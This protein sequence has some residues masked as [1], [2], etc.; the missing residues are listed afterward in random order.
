MIGA[1]DAMANGVAGGKPVVGNWAPTGARGARLRVMMTVDAVGG[2]WRYAMVLGRALAPLGIRCVFVGLGPRPSAEQVDEAEEIGDLVWLNQ[3]LD[4]TVED[5][6]ALDRLPQV[7][8]PLIGRFGI[9][10]LQLNLPSQA[11]GLDVE[12]PL[13]TVCH[14]CMITWWQT[15]RAEPLPETWRWKALRNRRG[16][17]RADAIVV[18]SRSLARQMEQCYG[19]LPP[20][21]V[22]YNASGATVQD[23]VKADYVFAAGRWWDEG[24]N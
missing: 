20:L 14:S 10:V 13:L 17:E 8:E 12:V 18:P 22:V 15:M 19:P 11:C 6:A 24:K 1:S 2:V 7:I 21:E 23:D 9:D 5:Q 4:W 3:P 16:F